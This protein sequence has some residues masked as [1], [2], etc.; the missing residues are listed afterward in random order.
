VAGEVPVKTECWPSPDQGNKWDQEKVDYSFLPS[1]AVEEVLKIYMGGAKKYGRGNYLKGISYSRVFSAAMRH[2]WA[3]WRGEET[4]PES[5]LSHL[6]HA[7]WNCLTLLEYTQG[8]YKK[9][10]DRG[11]NDGSK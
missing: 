8:Q 10:D 11:G 1:K 7:I 4:D 2:L 6:S 9:F 5:G 3:W